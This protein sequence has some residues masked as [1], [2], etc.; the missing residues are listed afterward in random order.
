MARGHK[1]MLVLDTAGGAARP[2][3]V[4]RAALRLLA[5][6]GGRF[7][8]AGVH[9]AFKFFD[10]QGARG[11]PSRASDF[12]ELG[13]RSWEDFEAELEA[14]LGAGVRGAHLPGPA[15]RASHTH[16]ALMETLL[17][18][19][20][21]RPE[22][23]SPAKPVLRSRGRRLLDA[24]G[25]AEEAGAALGGPANAVFLVA[26]CPR[27]RRELLQFVVGC[28]AQAPRAPPTPGQVME[29]LLP[30]RIR[31]AMGA[32]S[33]TL[34]WVDTT[35]RA[36]L[37][38]SPDDDGYWTVC[39]LLHR[40]GGA[41][42][43]S[44]IFSQGFSRT[45]EAV[46]E[47][48][49]K[50]PST[51]HLSPWSLAWP[52][53]ATLNRLLY[54]SPEHEASFPRIEG[55]LFLPVKG[56]ETEEAWTVILEPLAMNQRHFQKPVSIFLKDSV[57]QWSLPM[58][59]SLGTDCWML[60]C[61][62]EARAAQGPVLQQLAHT[63]TAKGLHLVVTV[64]PGEDWLP[65]TGVISPLSAC[66]VILT[67]F[68]TKEVEFQR[69]FPQPVNAGGIEDSPPAFSHVV[70]DV[71]SQLPDS[72][73]SPASCA[74]DPEWAQQELRHSKPWSPAMMETWFPFSNISGATSNLMESFCLLQAASTGMEASSETE[75]ELT[76]GLSELYHS[77]SSEEST[78]AN[79]EDW[80]KKRGVP[81]TPVRQ[82]MDAMCRSLKMLNV[83]R[84]N[85]KAQ[86]LHPDGSPDAAGERGTHK[87]ARAVRGRTSSKLKDF[88][89]EEDLLSYLR[90]CYQKAVATRETGLY[91]CAQNMVSTMKAFLK[92]KGTTELEEN[93]LNHVKS[94]LLATSKSL[95]QNLEKALNKEDKI[96]ECQL[97]VFLRLEMC[98]QCPSIR[99]CLN[100][101]E[102]VVEEE[103]TELLRLVSRAE[104]S[105]FLSEF[106]EEILQLYIDSIPETLGKLYDSLAFQIPGKL[107]AVL[108]A[109]FFSDDSMTQES[110]S[111]P[112]SGPPGPGPAPGSAASEQLE[113]LRTRSAKK[114]RK[115]T[116]I[117]HKS[118]ADV[119]QTLRQIEIP[120]VSKRATRNGS[121]QP[122]PPPPVKDTAV[123]EVTKVRR[124][125]FN[126]EMLSPS[127]RSLK[128]GLPRSHSVSAVEG[129]QK[130]RSSAPQ[131]Y[132]RL[133]TKRV[134]ETPVH[135]QT[136]RRLL[137]RQLQGRSSDPGP[138]GDV[139][140]ESPEKGEGE[141]ILR[142]SPRIKLLSLG[143][144]QSS[145]FYSVSQPKSRS[146]QRVHSFQQDTSDKRETSPV[147]CIQSPKRLLFG[148]L[149]EVVSPAEKGT[150]RVEKH[151]RSMPGSEVPAA[152]Q[153][154]RK[155]CEPSPTFSK[156]TPRKCR[157]R[158]RTPSP[159]P[160]SPQAAQGTPAK[161][162]AAQASSPGRDSLG[163]SE[164]PQ[165]G[166]S[167]AAETPPLGTKTPR[168][169]GRA[170]GSP[171]P[172]VLDP[173]WPH[174]VTPSPQD[175][176]PSPTQPGSGGPSSVGSPLRTPPRAKPPLHD[177]TPT[178]R[179]GLASPGSAARRAPPR[180]PPGEVEWGDP[181]PC[182][183]TPRRRSAPPA[184]TG[185]WDRRGWDRRGAGP[186]AGRSRSEGAAA[187]VLSPA[188]RT[189]PGEPRSPAPPPEHLT[190]LEE[191]ECCGWPPGADPE[192]RP[193]AAPRTYE[194]ELEL[195]A[196]GRP[197]LRIRPRPARRRAEGSP[198]GPG[199]PPPAERCP[200]PAHGRAQ[201][202][203]CRACTPSRG[204][205]WTPSPRQAG[206]TTP[207]DA[208]RA[209]PRR[210][211]AVDCGGGELDGVGRLPDL[212]PPPAQPEQG[213]KR[214]RDAPRGDAGSPDHEVLLSGLGPRPAH[215]W[216]P[217]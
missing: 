35:E 152:Y 194:L 59:D 134:A 135:K 160:A 32:R 54:N 159:T 187:P 141:A 130:T 124:N 41:V 23:T 202:F 158:L 161:L 97:Q 120:K 137:H 114:R 10:S 217:S 177:P 86:K 127:K 96:R 38:D 91:S 122:A 189:E 83:A 105:A 45:G 118:L 109:H 58:G 164:V 19:Q 147:L 146:V 171:P 25:E 17:D 170:A 212:T 34:Y 78:L 33:I 56:K 197:R 39:E 113:E 57:A 213:P 190:L 205:P 68:R 104:D 191:A 99:E 28:E 121:S 77:K 24:E 53:D 70:E 64:E 142:R 111:P 208:I 133:L 12:R 144:A 150:A 181:L 11:R 125:L 95:Q 100:E 126:Q 73:E 108:P 88:K 107:A 198:P 102:Q 112:A 188:A 165:E 80:R 60:Q 75:S 154:P 51:L 103:V 26:P 167:L 200:L 37:W 72:F 178:P 29:K 110:K 89:T 123:Q 210:K 16:S 139:V 148:A 155:D 49:G 81:R 87:P 199:S 172:S 15:P 90:E 176:A 151:S 180:P 204:A 182:P 93:C 30:R 201:T 67:V 185:R 62:E 92:S 76:H 5:Y 63:L 71:L 21:D 149:G 168:T 203:I 193:L 43:P 153:T 31:E 47:Q 101:M 206:K 138:G 106:L 195:E 7:G 162:A 84:L 175:L 48:E 94:N 9:W 157:R 163:T 69:C 136:S 145:S 215:A 4:R 27:S 128:R 115:N 52:A 156:S 20:W 214:A 74:P 44:E 166:P 79:P 117:R 131:G 85:A 192:P 184:D 66:A 42:L 116:L 186:P 6:L 61:P 65:V 216:P 174:A 13:T 119:S 1:V 207:P 82:K 129:L 40:G 3:R 8:L 143:R 140:E 22:I 14:R 46:L 179:A 183:S 169:P 173:E 209:W 36:E 2:G 18:Y 211:R 132:H 55:T 98:L 196:D 50:L